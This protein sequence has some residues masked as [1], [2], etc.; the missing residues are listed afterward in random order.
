M[1]Q[2]IKKK[3]QTLLFGPIRV[4][5]KSDQIEMYIFLFKRL[6]FKTKL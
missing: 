5:D 2:F 1:L 6:Y 4:W 3:V